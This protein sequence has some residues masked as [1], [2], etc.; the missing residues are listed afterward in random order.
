MVVTLHLVVENLA[1]L[2]G[3]VGDQLGLDDLEDVVAD[4]REFR[5]DL[6]LVVADQ[7]QL[8]ALF[9]ASIGA[10]RGE[11]RAATRN[12]RQEYRRERGKFQSWFSI[13]CSSAEFRRHACVMR[14]CTRTGT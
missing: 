5:L 11:N 3:G 1:L 2:R 9:G 8:V 6:G 4:V 7:R 12:I 10:D 14:S 13:Q